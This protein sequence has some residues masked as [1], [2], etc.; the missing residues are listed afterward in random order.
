[1]QNITPTFH[2]ELFLVSVSSPP[3]VFPCHPLY[4]HEGRGLSE[5][6]RSGHI[7]VYTYIHVQT[8]VQTYRDTVEGY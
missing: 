1:M 8:H 5:V 6:F 4:I 3:R 7:Y 2:T